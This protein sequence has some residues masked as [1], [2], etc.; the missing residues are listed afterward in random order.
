MKAPDKRLRN[1]FEMPRKIYGEINAMK[2]FWK[3][4]KAN[5]YVSLYRVVYLCICVREWDYVSLHKWKCVYVCIILYQNNQCLTHF[6]YKQNYIRKII[7][8]SWNSAS[9][10]VGF[11]DE[12]VAILISN[13]IVL[14]PQIKN[15]EVRPLVLKTDILSTTWSIAG[16][17]SSHKVLYWTKLNWKI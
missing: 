15:T 10:Q 2:H 7:S 11:V 1:S 8:F 6:P 5:A 9:F 17:Q 12:T 13:N 3:D 4:Y 16:T 14:R